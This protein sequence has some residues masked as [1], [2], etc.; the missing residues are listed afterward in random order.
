MGVSL[1]KIFTP[2]KFD[3]YC[4]VDCC[5]AKILKTKRRMENCGRKYVVQKIFENK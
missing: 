3:S 4:S 1:K 2:I 5:E